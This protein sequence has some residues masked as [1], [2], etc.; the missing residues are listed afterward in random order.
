MR[1]YGFEHEMVYM[2]LTGDVLDVVFSMCVAHVTDSAYQN[3]YTDDVSH[4]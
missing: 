1:S 3:C 2:I 4:T